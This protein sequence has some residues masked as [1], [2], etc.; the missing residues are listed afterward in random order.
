MIRRARGW[1]ESQGVRNPERMVG[2]L[3][4]GSWG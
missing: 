2:M 1:M 3:V 4:P